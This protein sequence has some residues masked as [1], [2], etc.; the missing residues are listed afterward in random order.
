M[1]EIS[2]HRRTALK[3]VN[4]IQHYSDNKRELKFRVTLSSSN[5]DSER[6]FTY[7]IGFEMILRCQKMSNK[8]QTYVAE[9][10]ITLPL[11][12]LVKLNYAKH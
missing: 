8:L 5:I 1:L 7:E 4:V 3:Q 9:N 10:W 6:Q 2:H 12:R 11:L